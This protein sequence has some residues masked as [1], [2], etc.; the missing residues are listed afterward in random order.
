MRRKRCGAGADDAGEPVR[1]LTVIILNSLGYATI[2]AEDGPSA[3]RALSAEDAIDLLLTDMVLPGGMSGADI[4]ALAVETRPDLGVLYVS[5]YTRGE[6]VNRGRIDAGV[7]LLQKPFTTS[8]LAHHVRDA[9][10][11][12]L[13]GS[14][15]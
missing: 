14:S 5:G 4:A 2:E 1:E 9:I 11:D 15:I 6:I 8:E 3:V 10:R 7:R 12:S 13:A